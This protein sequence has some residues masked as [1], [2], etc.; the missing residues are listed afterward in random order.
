MRIVG[1][2]AQNQHGSSLSYQ[3]IFYFCRLIPRGLT[4]LVLSFSLFFNLS[5]G[6]SPSDS[7][8]LSYR[9]AAQRRDTHTVPPLNAK[10]KL[11]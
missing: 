4:A 3:I 9:L 8:F 2:V 6:P 7:F 10:F 1:F 5:P 11:Y